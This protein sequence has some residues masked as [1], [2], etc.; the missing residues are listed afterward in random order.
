MAEYGVRHACGHDE[1]HRLYGPGKE[2]DRKIEWL[3]TTICSE[4]YKAQQAAARETASKQAA[5]ANADAGLPALTGSDKQ[6]AW[7]ETI[8]RPVVD[9]LIK[10]RDK[11]ASANRPQW[12]S[13]RAHVEAVKALATVAGEI[14]AQTSAKWWIDNRNRFCEGT[15]DGNPVMVWLY[16]QIRERGLAPTAMAEFDDAESR[17]RSK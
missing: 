17:R 15:I 10:T 3:E 9:A 14:I 5:K 11:V 2:R 12:A 7:A 13:E 16:I 8:R 6:V 1:V 4:C